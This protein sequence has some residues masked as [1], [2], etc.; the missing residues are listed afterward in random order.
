MAPA[1]SA[2]R[3][4][5]LARSSHA[6]A[7]SGPDATARSASASASGM[8]SKGAQERSSA[9][10]RGK[11]DRAHC[12]PLCRFGRYS[13]FFGDSVQVGRE[14]KTSRGE[15]VHV[16]GVEPGQF[17][18]VTRGDRETK[19]SPQ[20][21][22]RRGESDRFVGVARGVGRSSQCESRQ[23][24]GRQPFGANRG[25]GFLMPGLIEQACQ[26]GFGDVGSAGP[27]CDQ[28]MAEPRRRIVGIFAEQPFVIGPRPGPSGWPELDV[29]SSRDSAGRGG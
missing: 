16:V 24:P 11:L 28:G 2:A 7:A 9:H 22:G 18:F 15:A 21:A 27:E 10:P 19:S 14:R 1:G 4:R 26:V 25:V 5:T 8:I 20:P 29:D 23:R 17:R 13:Q 3:R 6:S 12:S